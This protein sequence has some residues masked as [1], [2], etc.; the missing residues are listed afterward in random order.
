MTAMYLY[1][2]KEASPKVKDVQSELACALLAALS[3][4]TAAIAA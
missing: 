3:K 4:A 1:E 2:L